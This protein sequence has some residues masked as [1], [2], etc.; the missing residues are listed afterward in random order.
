MTLRHLYIDLDDTL[1]P[2]DSFP[3]Y[4]WKILPRIGVRSLPF[5]AGLPYRSLPGKRRLLRPAL[6]HALK[7]L[8]CAP[9]DEMGA[10]FAREVLYPQA[11]LWLPQAAKALPALPA[12]G[13]AHV[14]V[15]VHE[16]PLATTGLGITLASM[17]LDMVVEPLA[18]LMGADALSTRLEREG[19]VF[20]G[21]LAGPQCAGKGKADM[22]AAHAAG[23]GISLSEAG[24]ITDHHRDIP[25]LEIVGQRYLINPSERL[26]EWNRRT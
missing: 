15:P 25:A 10:R 8:P 16:K 21:R 11:R 20:T 23:F 3:P 9:I 1:V 19:G 22:I 7:G 2:F 13:K 6:A 17:S 26:T 5:L 24:L 4:L 12:S 14:I 18:A